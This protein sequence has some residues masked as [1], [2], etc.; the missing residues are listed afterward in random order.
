MITNF[1]Q[2]KA[3]VSCELCGVILKF[4]E[5]TRNSDAA[6]GAGCV[7]GLWLSVCMGGGVQSLTLVAGVNISVPEEQVMGLGVCLGVCLGVSLA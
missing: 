5:S 6:I 3:Y 7:E 4:W 2:R 1:C